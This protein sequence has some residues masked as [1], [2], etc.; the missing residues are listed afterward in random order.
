MQGKWRRGAT[1]SSKNE[2]QNGKNA[3]VPYFTLP[4]FENI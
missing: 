4:E 1:D 2:F 3:Q